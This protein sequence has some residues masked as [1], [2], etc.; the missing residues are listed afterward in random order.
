[1]RLDRSLRRAAFTVS[2]IAFVVP[3]MLGAMTAC[4]DGKKRKTPAPVKTAAPVAIDDEP[5]PDPDPVDPAAQP[6]TDTASVSSGYPAPIASA[7]PPKPHPDQ[8]NILV[9]VA[10]DLR[11]DT[12]ACLPSLRKNVIERGVTFSAHYASSPHRGPARA[13]L[14]TG[15]SPRHH[16]VTIADDEGAPSTTTS[17]AAAFEQAKNDDRV[18]A[19]Y[20]HDAGYTTGLFGDYLEGYETQFQKQKYMPAHWDEWHAFAR[21]TDFDFQLVERGKGLEAAR[22]RCFVSNGGKTPRDAK[23]VAGADDIIDDHRENHATDIL[24]ERVLSFIKDAADARKP[25]FAYVAPRAVRSPSISPARYQPDRRKPSFSPAAIE[26]LQGCALFASTAP[27]ASVFEKDVSDKPEWVQALQ[28]DAAKAPPKVDEIRQKQL[29]AAL[30]IDDTLDEILAALDAST[31]RDNTVIILTSDV[32]T[33]WG[34]HGVIGKTCAYDECIR[35]PLVIFDPRHPAGLSRDEKA[36]TVDVDL[37]PTIAA[38]AHAKLPADAHIDGADLSPLVF[39]AKAS[40]PHLQVITESRATVD[41]GEKSPRPSR[42]GAYVALHTP[43]WLYVEYFT[44]ETH[45]TARTRKDGALETELYDLS[46]DPLLLDNLA[47]MPD[48]S[49]RERGYAQSEIEKVMATLKPTLKKLASE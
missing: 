34:E 13:S 36:I 28:N 5:D 47:R 12:L 40:W 49:R 1:M 48:A 45:K 8:P 17:S 29:V 31:E 14:L 7:P 39:D 24:K 26:K 22:S 32:G 3:A 19:K 42:S 30:A 35:T 2:L 25:F 27:S 11:A 43:R 4:S 37:T 20:V 46:K 10:S 15:L 23:C 21:S 38:L 9:I 33:S 44:D 6:P 18:I 41:A 16:G